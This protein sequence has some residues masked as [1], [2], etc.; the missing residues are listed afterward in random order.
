MISSNDTTILTM[1]SR[2]PDIPAEE[3]DKYIAKI[4][5]EDNIPICHAIIG[6]ISPDAL[7]G[8]SRQTYD[9]F[10]RWSDDRTRRVRQQ[11]YV[12]RRNNKETDLSLKMNQLHA[13]GIISDEVMMLYGISGPLPERNTYVAMSPEEKL[14]LWEEKL[15]NRFGPNW[16]SRFGDNVT[17]L[18]IF[19]TRKIT[20]VQPIN[21]QREGF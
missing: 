6:R 18:P 20:C 4:H 9:E 8:D 21:W 3:A 13:K 2:Y 16:R 14:A 15:A 19:T 10:K 7:E 5:N 12:A 1:L 11:Q 17:N